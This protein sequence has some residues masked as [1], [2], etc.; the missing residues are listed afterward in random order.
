MALQFEIEV[1]LVG[2]GIIGVGV[3]FYILYGK[4]KEISK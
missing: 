4:R 3:I 2:V 1:I